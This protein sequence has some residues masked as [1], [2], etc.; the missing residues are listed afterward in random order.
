MS[1]SRGATTSARVTGSRSQTTVTR[2][3]TGQ[4]AAAIPATARG[5]RIRGQ[6][7]LLGGVD[8]SLAA[9]GEGR[10][11]RS[12][13]REAESAGTTSGAGASG[14]GAGAISRVG[15]GATSGAGAGV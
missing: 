13:G 2:K 4:S 10:S 1:P 5:P 9:G 7:G 15:V 14:A 3:G 8:G 11:D 6:S 12:D